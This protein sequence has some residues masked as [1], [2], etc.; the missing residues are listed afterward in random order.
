[1]SG[2]LAGGTGMMSVRDATAASPQTIDIGVVLDEASWSGLQKRV[3]V[4]VSLVIVLDGLDTQTLTLAIPSIIREWG[5]GRGPFGWVLAVG[6]IAMAIGTAYGGMLGDRLGRRGALLASTAIF[7]AGTL[8]GA[9]THDV[10]W[11]GTT[12]VLASIGLGA[13][14]PNATA[15]V[16][17]YTPQA[18]RS[19]ALAIAMGSQPIGT[20]IGG[21]LAAYILPRGSWKTLFVVCGVIPLAGG[22]LLLFMLPESIR[23]LLARRGDARRIASLLTRLG[24]PAAAGATF[25]DSGEDRPARASLRELFTPAHR[26]DTLALSGALFC[27]IFTNLFVLSWTPSLL[28]SL[29]YAAG[30]TSMASASV[31][32]GGLLGAIGGG[33]LFAR[34]G[35][36]R[37]LSFMTGGAVATA[38]V[39]VLTPIGPVGAGAAA[40]LLLL[41]VAGMFIPGTQVQLFSLAGQAYPTSIRATGIGL[42][43]AVGRI[44]A[45]G[46]GL[47]GP[48]LIPAGSPG[49][50]GAVACAMVASG[51]L[52]LGTRTVVRPSVRPAGQTLTGD[53]AAPQPAA[54]AELS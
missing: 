42:V 50:F 14:M 18:R 32:I 24:H 54:G 45:V 21:M 12:R 44:G 23:F 40:V 53:V 16:A 46:S 1:M 47:V 17:E 19:L 11:L 39:L 52:L 48:L 30:V 4:L 22:V 2:Q 13:A 5:I 25:I 28:A 36:R 38:L 35:S 31:S 15:M 26:R 51:L 34:I 27:V 8:A 7:G 9:A 10:W 33:V 3:L 29:G 41:L 49:F 6:F 37:A 43:A 20:F